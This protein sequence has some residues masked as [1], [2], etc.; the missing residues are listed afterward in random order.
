MLFECSMRLSPLL[1]CLTT[2]GSSRMLQCI[3][4]SVYACDDHWVINACST[5]ED[6]PSDVR[7]KDNS[8]IHCIFSHENGSHFGTHGVKRYTTNWFPVP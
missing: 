6:V 5:I 7:H 1:S 3:V 8:P 4:A 2:P